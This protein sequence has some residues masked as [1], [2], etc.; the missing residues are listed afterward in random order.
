MII[1]ATYI[2]EYIFVFKFEVLAVCTH[3]GVMCDHKLSPHHVDK[4]CVDTT[5]F[6]PNGNLLLYYE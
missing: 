5:D 1:R 6:P 4:S 3:P 2:I